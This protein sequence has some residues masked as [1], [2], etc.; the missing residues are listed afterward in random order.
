MNDSGSSIDR[1][2]YIMKRIIIISMIIL[3]LAAAYGYTMMGMMSMTPDEHA[4][5]MISM[6][7]GMMGNGMMRGR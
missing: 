6:H 4:G 5:M 1:K 7:G 2:E 3:I